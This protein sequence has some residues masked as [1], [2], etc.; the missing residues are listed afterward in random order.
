SIDRTMR[1]IFLATLCCTVVLLVTYTGY[2]S[3]KTWKQR[4]MLS[5]A[6]SFIAK[7]DARNAALSLDQV[8]DANPRN[9]EACRLMA[10]LTEATRSPNAV[11][12]RSR[13]RKSTRLNS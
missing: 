9:V 1:K 6:R 10:E 5:L 7:S 13:D 8:L 4:H 11:L 2:R 12:W 3:Y